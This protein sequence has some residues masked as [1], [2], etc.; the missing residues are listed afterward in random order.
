MHE[1][2]RLARSQQGA[3]AASRVINASP[4]DLGGW[5]VV[6]TIPALPRP[7]QW[8]SVP[9][10]GVSNCNNFL[11]QLICALRWPK[12]NALVEAP[13]HMQLRIG[14]SQRPWAV[15]LANISGSDLLRSYIAVICPL[16]TASPR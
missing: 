8:R 13:R 1:D 3:L 2:G 15:E 4:H 10:A 12:R 5:S 6:P 11:D 14:I 16:G 7:P 9:I